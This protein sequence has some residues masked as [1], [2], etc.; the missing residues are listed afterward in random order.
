MQI[1][2]I[3]TLQKDNHNNT[4]KSKKSYQYQNTKEKMHNICTALEMDANDYNPQK[5]VDNISRYLSSDNR[6]DRILYSEISNH[7]YE[8]DSVHRGNFNTNIESLL[9]YAIKNDSLVEEDCKKIIIKIYDHFHLALYQIENV[10]N[11]FAEGIEETK[12]NLN[13]QVKSIEK[14]YI[15][16]LGIFAA[17]ILTFVGGMAFSTSVLQN[18]ASVSIYRLLITTDFL[19]FVFINVVYLLISLV[20]TKCRRKALASA[21]GI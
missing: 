7:V 18:M 17:I 8:L 14:E 1:S 12:E 9:F 13:K 11:I 19:A 20:L 4:Q 16:I 21:M 5:T 3:D 15:S 6:L 10:N 2:K